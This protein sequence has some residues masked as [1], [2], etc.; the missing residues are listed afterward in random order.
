M[1]KLSGILT[2]ILSLLS[3]Q[4]I[5]GNAWDEFITFDSATTQD[6]PSQGQFVST[7]SGLD[8]PKVHPINGTAYDWWYFDAVSADAKSSFVIVFYTASQRGLPFA[9]ENTT[10]VSLTLDAKFPNGTIYSISLPA[11]S[12]TIVSI[13]NGTT[14]LFKGSHSSWTSTPDLSQYIVS[15]DDPSSG[16][17]G[18]L[19]LNS[20]GYQLQ[21]ESYLTVL[22]LITNSASHKHS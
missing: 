22:V 9:A 14:G 11:T 15:I 7:S 12:A 6:G 3:L 17:K 8:A 5:S 2:I 1:K 16:I 20:V 18:T 21:I 4:V 13:G 19:K 10:V